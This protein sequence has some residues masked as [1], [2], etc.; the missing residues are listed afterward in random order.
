MPPA[1]K[2]P[3]PPPIPPKGI[4]PRPAPAPA[5]N[6]APAPTPAPPRLAL[7]DDSVVAYVLVPDEEADL[8]L[9]KWTVTPSS[10]LY[11]AIVFSSFKIFPNH[12]IS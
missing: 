8:P 9:T 11:S 6:P 7:V 3:K 10:I 2:P 1:G 4:P 5:P 12:Q